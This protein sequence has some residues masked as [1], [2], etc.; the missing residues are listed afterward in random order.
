MYGIKLN[1]RGSQDLVVQGGFGQE[2]GMDLKYGEMIYNDFQQWRSMIY[3]YFKNF[4][5]LSFF[6]F[7]IEINVD[8][9]ELGDERVIVVLCER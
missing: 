7:C 9:E 2:F 1:G 8:K 5:W 6:S 3:L 4:F